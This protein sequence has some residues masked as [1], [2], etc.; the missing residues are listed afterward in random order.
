M[1]TRK[2]K[3]LVALQHLTDHLYNPSTSKKRTTIDDMF[4]EQHYNTYAKLL[5]T[6]PDGLKPFFEDM[7]S[8]CSRYKTV[9]LGLYLK[10]IYQG[11]VPT[12]F[13]PESWEDEMDLYQACV[14]MSLE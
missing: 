4:I 8:D 13:T 11:V 3:Q 6:L 5:Q 2:E 7:T 9:W 1:G 14:N 10:S 12:I